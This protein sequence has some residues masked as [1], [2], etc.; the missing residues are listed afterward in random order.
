MDKVKRG[1]NCQ[2]CLDCVRMI[3]GGVSWRCYGQDDMVE[4]K[5]DICE[6]ETPPKNAPEWCPHREKK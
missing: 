6:G 3:G 1:T 2:R 4:L 5:R